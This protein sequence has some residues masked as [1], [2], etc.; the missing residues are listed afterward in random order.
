MDRRTVPTRMAMLFAAGAM[1]ATAGCAG[2]GSPSPAGRMLEYGVPSPPTATYHSADTILSIASMPSGDVPTTI[3]TLTTL[4]LEFAPDP[5]G[6]RV[7]GTL[8]NLEGSMSTPMTGSM[9]IPAPDVAGTLEFVMD[10]RGGVEIISMP[11]LPAA[12]MQMSPQPNMVQPFFPPLPD[13]TLEPG[14]T[15]V[16]TTEV[17]PGMEFGGLDAAMDGNSTTVTA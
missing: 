13:G 3:S 11:A 10:H 12:G 2:P 9:P 6:L 16:D 17:S 8:A 7:T 4:V 15:W 14:S 1:L 5:V